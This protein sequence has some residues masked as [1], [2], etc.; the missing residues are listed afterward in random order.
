MNDQLTPDERA[1]LRARIV[2]GARDIKPAGAHRGAWIA[3]SVAALLVVALAGGVAATATLSA[4]P[5]AN[6]PSP[7]PTATVSPVPTP[8]A[9]PTPTPTST[10]RAPIVAFGG[11]C[12]AVLTDEEATEFSGIPM[13][14]MSF[15]PV[16]DERWLG[17]LD[18]EWRAADADTYWALSVTVLPWASVPDEVRAQSG[19]VPACEG[20]AICDYSQR[21]GDAWVAVA[22]SEASPLVEVADTVGARAS[23]SPGVPTSLV[24]SAW[25]LTDCEA[26]L[27]NAVAAG[28]GRDDLRPIGTDN[29]PHGQVWDVLVANGFAAWCSFTAGP[30]EEVD[31]PNLRV[32]L[33][34]GAQAD[35]RE[36]SAF[37]GVPVSV[38]G[39]DAAWWIPAADGLGARVFAAAPGGI[40]EVEVG[41]LSQE[42]ASTVTAEILFALG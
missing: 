29:V 42:R 25:Q 38:T 5:V 7:S 22:A 33:A 13:R 32:S 17:G 31:A 28:L 4:P 21:F 20:G 14:A 1:A 8:T 30:Y 26:Q 10:P 40:V 6:T 27:R 23:Q 9:S 41:N 3:G 16:W 12:A 35:A 15:L 19:V 37:G 24:A 2:G 39:A 18:C 36:V 34:A 11:D